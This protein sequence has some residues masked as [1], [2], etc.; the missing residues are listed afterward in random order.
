MEDFWSH[1]GHV[2]RVLGL[3]CYPLRDPVYVLLG[4]LAT[5][6][7]GAIGD[8]RAG[9]F[10]IG[11][12]VVVHPIVFFV[13][14]DVRRLLGLTSGV[15]GVLDRKTIL[16]LIDSTTIPFPYSSS[17]QEIQKDSTYVVFSGETFFL[18]PS[19]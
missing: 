1:S 14:L 12:I 18:F 16:A 9:A 11:I 15:L 5:P 7:C 2:T 10:G 6:G 19:S 17:P 3:N 4:C 8:R 13:V